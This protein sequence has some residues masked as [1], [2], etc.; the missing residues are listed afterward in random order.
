MLM[1]GAGELS[2]ER[3][4]LTAKEAAAYIEVSLRFLQLH[5]DD[6][7]PTWIV[8]GRLRY[9]RDVL[10]KYLDRMRYKIT[11]SIMAAGLAPA[12]GIPQRA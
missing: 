6:I 3:G 4:Y 5:R 1:N 11:G 9:T 2:N 12:I 8:A 10:D 7:P